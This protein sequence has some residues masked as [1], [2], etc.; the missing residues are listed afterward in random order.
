MLGPD[1]LGSVKL[2]QSYDDALQTG[3]MSPLPDINGPGVCKRARFK[4]AGDDARAGVVW[5][6]ELRVISIGGYAGI[7]TPEGVRIGTS[8]EDL[9]KAYPAWRDMDGRPNDEK[10]RSDVLVPGNAQ[11]AYRITISNGVVDSVTLESVER[12]CYE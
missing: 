7:S 6:H 11:A 8:L 1:G 10:G 2:G 4:E 12:A 9:K 3:V 5:F